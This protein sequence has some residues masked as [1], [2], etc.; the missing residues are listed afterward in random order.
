ML[1]NL[2]IDILQG[3]INCR[4]KYFTTNLQN[5]LISKTNF[6]TCGQTIKTYLCISFPLKVSTILYFILLESIQ[7]EETDNLIKSL[8]KFEMEIS[9]NY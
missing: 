2:E 4:K 6:L 1:I 3:Y 9:K 8:S 7:S 5:K